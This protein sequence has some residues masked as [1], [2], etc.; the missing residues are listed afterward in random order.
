VAAETTGIA[1][2]LVTTAPAAMT[3]VFC[4]KPRTALLATASRAWIFAVAAAAATAAAV[5]IVEFVVGQARAFGGVIDR[6]TLLK[7]HMH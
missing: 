4:D 3:G 5:G 1:P 7:K 2:T 6:P